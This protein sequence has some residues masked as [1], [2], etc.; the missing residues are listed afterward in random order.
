MS[1]PSFAELDQLATDELRERAFALA[2]ERHDLRFFWSVLRH[3]PHAA[4]AEV[5][6]ADLGEVGV[7]FEEA[8]RLWRELTGRHGYGGAEPLLRAAFIDYLLPPA[9]SQPPSA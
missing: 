7:Q 2:R 5:A 6:D 1:N 9:G 4:D 3:L 8:V